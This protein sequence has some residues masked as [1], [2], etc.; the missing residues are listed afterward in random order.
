MSSSTMLHNVLTTDVA[1]AVVVTR[2]EAWEMLL[3]QL[4]FDA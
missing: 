3:A 4:G 2:T 1:T